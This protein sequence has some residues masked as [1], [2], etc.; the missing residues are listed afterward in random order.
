MPVGPPSTS[1]SLLAP[2]VVVESKGR[3]SWI[4]PNL[5]G[6]LRWRDRAGCWL[7]SPLRSCSGQDRPGP[8]TTTILP[9]DGR[10]VV[11]GEGSSACRRTMPS[12]SWRYHQGKERQGGGRRQLE[13]HDRR[14]G[15]APGGGIAQKDIQT[16]QF[17]IQPVYASP[18]PRTEPKL[19]G[20]SAS[21]QVTVKTHQISK[22]GEILDRLVTAGATDVGN[23]H[24]CSPTRRR[25]SI[26]PARRRSLTPA[27]KRN[28]MH[29]LRD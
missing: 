22:L 24:S 15:G 4:Y 7:A 8:S 1:A 6:G 27:A 14:Y 21:N 13:S 17:S 2:A 25:P 3:R 9:A 19:S 11:I 16:S 28:S 29:A 18:E 5:L 12:Q 10:F 23:V 20:Y 26:K